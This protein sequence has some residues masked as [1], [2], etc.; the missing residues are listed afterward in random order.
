[1]RVAC[2][3]PAFNEAGRICQVLEAVAACPLVSEII[4][5][6]DGSSDGTAGAAMRHPDVRVYRLPHNVGKG[7]AMRAGATV[8]SAD[9]LLFLD[10]DLLNLQPCHVS[11]LLEPVLSGEAAMSIGRFCGG[12]F[13]TDLAQRVSPN[14]SGQRAIRRS[15]FLEVPRLDCSRM[16]VEVRINRYARRRRWPVRRVPLHGVTHPMKEE[17]LGLLRGAIERARMYRDILLTVLLDRNGF[18]SD[19]QSDFAA[20]NLV[21]HE[22]GGVE[23]GS[24]T[25]L[26]TP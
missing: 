20:A 1:M 17:K 2:I 9:V 7:A 19:P 25:K 12:R 6:D 24:G 10:A 13:L 21:R 16:D 5:V 3:V 23:S 18:R 4:V 14:I 11:V 8:T 26:P 22:P 15:L